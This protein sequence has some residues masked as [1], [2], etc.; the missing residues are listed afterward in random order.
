MVTAR[1][2]NRPNRNTIASLT[3]ARY[4]FSAPKALL[5][6]EE[7][8]L[9]REDDWIRNWILHTYQAGICRQGT[10]IILEGSFNAVKPTKLLCSCGNNFFLPTV[11]KILEIYSYTRVLGWGC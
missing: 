8:E 2:W 6:D 3:H 7:I 5:P 11:K 9:L 10:Y 4:Q 1:R